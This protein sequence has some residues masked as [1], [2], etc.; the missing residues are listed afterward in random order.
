MTAAKRGH[1]KIRKARRFDLAE[2]A[3]LNAR[4]Y[5]HSSKPSKKDTLFFEENCLGN[6]RL[7][8]VFVAIIEDR[9][10]G[11]LHCFDWASFGE[12]EK[13]RHIAH[14]MIAENV[15]RQG[16]GKALVMHVVADA[17]I[18]KFSR[19]DVQALKAEYGPNVFYDSLGF[20]QKNDEKNTYRMVL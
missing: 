15:Q 5:G 4:L 13:V 6:H 10:V 3:K 9:I 11:F 20:I 14:L 12:K 7:A 17:R 19:V 2:V 1:L 8:H 18:K 16:I